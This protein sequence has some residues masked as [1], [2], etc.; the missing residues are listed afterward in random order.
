M[1]LR[2]AVPGV[3]Q[4]WAFLVGCNAFFQ[5]RHISD[6]IFAQSLYYCRHSKIRLRQKNQT[7]DIKG[8][9]SIVNKMPVKY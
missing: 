6:E 4:I 5:Q 9:L 2:L 1:S 7:T 8:Y 3:V